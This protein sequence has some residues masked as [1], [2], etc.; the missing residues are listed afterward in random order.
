M[1]TDTLRLCSIHDRAELHQFFLRDPALFLYELGDLDD[2]Y[3]ENTVYFGLR[4]VTTK[5]LKAAM[6]QY[7]AEPPAVLLIMDDG[8]HALQKELLKRI[9]PFLAHRIYIHAPQNLVDDF[10]AFYDVIKNHGPHHRMFLSN[11][12][13]VVMTRTESVISLGPEDV[14]EIKHFYEIHYPGNFFDPHMLETNMYY[15]L[16]SSGA[17]GELFAIAGVH[18][19]SAEYKV[20]ALGST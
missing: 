9:L 17:T 4:D 6:L 19:V 3:F 11:N 20:A 12:S 1:S 2:F 13:T 10:S 15:G 14:E 5:E 8:K 16:R 7:V 18:S